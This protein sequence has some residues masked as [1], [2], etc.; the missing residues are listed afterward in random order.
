MYSHIQ[1]FHSQKTLDELGPEI[2]HGYWGSSVRVLLQSYHQMLVLK[3]Q[4][5]TF[6]TDLNKP[7]M[8]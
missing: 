6:P 4:H 2:N 3:V 1:L 7:I 8:T 5:S